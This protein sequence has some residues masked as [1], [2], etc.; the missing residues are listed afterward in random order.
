M[1]FTLAD[2]EVATKNDINKEKLTSLVRFK[3]NSLVKIL[4]IR[5]ERYNMQKTMNLI[6]PTL[7][8]LNVK[9][10]FAKN[11][12]IVPIEKLIPF[13]MLVSIFIEVKI[14]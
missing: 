11:A 10:L 3:T 14:K 1:K 13:E 4:I 7:A 12:N 6:Y 2:K 9:V 5:V 8:A